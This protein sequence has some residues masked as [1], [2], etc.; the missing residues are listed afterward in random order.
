MKK[1]KQWFCGLIMALYG[2]SIILCFV[3]LVFN[4]ISMMN[5]NGWEFVGY[6]VS[7]IFDLGLCVFMPYV[8][9]LQIQDGVHDRWK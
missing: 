8:L 4:F 5:S 3:A 6:F 2:A 1:I 7:F 9:F